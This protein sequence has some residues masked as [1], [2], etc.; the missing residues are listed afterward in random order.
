MGK[1]WARHKT[2]GEELNNGW[3]YTAVGGSRRLAVGSGW[4][5]PRAVL[6]KKNDFLRTALPNRTRLPSNCHHLPSIAVVSGPPSGV[7]FPTA[8][9]YPHLPS[10][11]LDRRAATPRHTS[12]TRIQNDRRLRAESVRSRSEFARIPFSGISQL[13]AA[14]KATETFHSMTAWAATRQPR[15]RGCP[16]LGP[17]PQPKPRPKS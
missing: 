15:G 10:G 13:N 17:P 8:I 7:D 4:R 11:V 12:L 3:R 2:T 9:S 5:F 16:S 6:N 14:S 1:T